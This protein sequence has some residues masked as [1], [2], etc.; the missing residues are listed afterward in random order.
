MRAGQRLR[1]LSVVYTGDHAVREVAVTVD[2][3]FKRRESFFFDIT[4][5]SLCVYPPK[6]REIESD[7][8]KE[9]YQERN[10]Y[11]DSD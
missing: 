6:E 2:T 5:R 7:S 9:R 3:D 10:T 4:I 11:R 8:D 1:V